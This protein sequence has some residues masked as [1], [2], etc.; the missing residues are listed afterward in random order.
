MQII[1]VYHRY[2]TVM[3][4]LVVIFVVMISRIDKK[5]VRIWVRGWVVI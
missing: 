1:M 5:M 2:S 4:I 3:V